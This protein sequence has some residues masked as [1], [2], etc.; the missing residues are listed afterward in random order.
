M[1]I[2]FGCVMLFNAIYLASYICYILMAAHTLD[3]VHHKC[4]LF[5]REIITKPKRMLCHEVV[6]VMLCNNMY[7]NILVYWEY[8]GH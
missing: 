5:S 7:N 8:T 6:Q 2:Y 4:H 3:I 1:A